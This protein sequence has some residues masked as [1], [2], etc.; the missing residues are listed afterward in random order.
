MGGGTY[1]C[2]DGDEEAFAAALFG[3]FDDSFGNVT[4]LVDL[5]LHK[6]GVRIQLV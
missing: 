2:V 4:V 6:F 5:S 3:V 1:R